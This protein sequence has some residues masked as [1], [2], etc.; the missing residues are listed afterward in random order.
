VQL[1]RTKKNFLIFETKETTDKEQEK[2]WDFVGSSNFTNYLAE[3]DCVSSLFIQSSGQIR[4]GLAA[5][6][7]SPS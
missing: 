6:Y 2:D 5:A 7:P 1:E 3:D 4:N